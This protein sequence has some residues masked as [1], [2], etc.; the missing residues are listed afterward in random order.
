[1]AA[2]SGIEIELLML[3][4]FPKLLLKEDRIEVTALPVAT[5]TP[6]AAASPEAT[7]AVLAPSNFK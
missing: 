4:N 1:L 6:A 3:E 5:A 2:S 7:T